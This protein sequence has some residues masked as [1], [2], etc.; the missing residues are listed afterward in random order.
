[1]RPAPNAITRAVCYDRR[2]T[3]H[4]P[5]LLITRPMAVQTCIAKQAARAA[6]TGAR[7]T[8]KTPEVRRHTSTADEAHMAMVEAS[9]SLP[10]ISTA[11]EG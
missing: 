3:R 11:L 6:H 9:Q 8:P 7:P 10:P 5:V 2:R 4:G 1:M